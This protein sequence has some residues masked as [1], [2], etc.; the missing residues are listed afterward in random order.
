MGALVK[1]KPR[2]TAGGEPFAEYGDVLTVAEVSRI[3]SVS[4]RVVREHCVSGELP[5][6]KIGPLWRIP[7]QRLVDLL[8][9]RTA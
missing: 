7:K 1:M 2:P 8:G 5:G 9:L 6:V 4:E 3:L